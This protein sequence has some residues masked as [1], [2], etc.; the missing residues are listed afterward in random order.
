M[1]SGMLSSRTPHAAGTSTL[2]STLVALQPPTGVN[3][4]DSAEENAKT[5]FQK[6]LRSVRLYPFMHTG[7]RPALV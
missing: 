6:G 2:T 4:L 5:F 3:A 1:G 7:K